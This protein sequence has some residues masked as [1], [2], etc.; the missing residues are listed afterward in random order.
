MDQVEERLFVKECFQRIVRGTID[1]IEHMIN[2][3]HSKTINV[4]LW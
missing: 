1:M 3:V 4:W 2:N